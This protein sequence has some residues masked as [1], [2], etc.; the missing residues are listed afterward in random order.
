MYVIQTGRNSVTG[1]EVIAHSAAHHEG[2]REV[3]SLRIDHS[4]GSLGVNPP[5]SEAAVKVGHNSPVRSDKITSNTH[6]ISPVSCFRSPRNRGERPAERKI[7]IAAKNPR[8]SN[9]IQLP[10]QRR[11]VGYKRVVK[12]R[13][14]YTH[15]LIEN[16]RRKGC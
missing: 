8:T 14:I 2:E 11:N 7:P 6:V 3:L 12:R 13:P 16:R 10:P 9:V 15:R 5:E 1:V 4:F